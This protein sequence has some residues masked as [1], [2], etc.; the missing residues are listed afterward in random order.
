MTLYRINYNGG[1]WRYPQN[2]FA[3]ATSKQSAKDKFDK[4]WVS[5]QRAYKGHRVDEPYDIIYSITRVYKGSDFYNIYRE[6]RRMG[7]NGIIIR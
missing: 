4:W 7:G 3:S 2:V 5:Q 6:A 1:A